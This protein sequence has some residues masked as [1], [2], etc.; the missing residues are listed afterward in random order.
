M[1]LKP[2]Q[3]KRLPLESGLKK[4]LKQDLPKAAEP[5]SGACCMA[6]INTSLPLNRVCEIDINNMRYNISRIKA[7]ADASHYDGMFAVV[8]G[9]AYGHG[10]LKTMEIAA[11]FGIHDFGVATLG[12]AVFLRKNGCQGRIL[13]LGPPL[14]EEF[15]FYA[16]H[17][18]D[19]MIPSEWVAKELIKWNETTHLTVDV[20]FMIDTGM[21]RIGLE[22][23]EAYSIISEI[24]H[25]TSSV[26]FIGLCTHL[27]DVT[28]DHGKEYTNMQFRRYLAV[29]NKLK[30]NG[31]NV[32]LF[33]I[34]NSDSLFEDAIDDEV[35]GQLLTAGTSGMSRTGS[36]IFG[37]AKGQ[38]PIMTFKATVR[39]IQVVSQGETV[40]YGRKYTPEED[41]LVATLSVGYADGYPKGCN[42]KA[43]VRIGNSNF[44]V[45]G[46]AMDMMM[47]LLGPKQDEEAQSVKLGDWAVL[48]GTREDDPCVYEIAKI[49]QV[50]MVE[51]TCGLGERVA[52]TF[53]N[54]TMNTGYE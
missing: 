40:G 10:V 26:K 9:N 30:R 23:Q 54:S 13:V 47:I 37:L 32:P 12:E 21:N 49:G 7:L 48:W 41:V 11:E 43:K 38:K 16:Y 8:K 19:M 2:D 51:I 50:G 53:V 35:I 6:A 17:R 4:P 14:P 27:N 15:N 52:R 31:I 36:A 42:L 28:G 18:I 5:V 29:F 3:V 46:M 20:H 33:H 25:Q 24:V 44:L 45:I 39:H 22:Y 1:P 34:E